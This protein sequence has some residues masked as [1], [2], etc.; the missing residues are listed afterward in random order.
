MVAELAE[1]V[2][3]SAGG[4]GFAP[5][6]EAVDEVAGAEVLLEQVG[7]EHVPDGGENGVADSDQCPFLAAAGGDPPVTGRAARSL[8]LTPGGRW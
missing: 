1:L 8:V 4:A 6:V 2:D 5:V 7:G 3:E